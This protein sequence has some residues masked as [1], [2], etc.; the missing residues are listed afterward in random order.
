MDHISVSQI[1][2]L[3]RCGRQYELRYLEKV[4]ATTSG[5]LVKGS[6]YHAALEAHFHQAIHGFQATLDVARISIT[7]AIIARDILCQMDF[8]GPFLTPRSTMSSSRV[9]TGGAIGLPDFVSPC[10]VVVPGV[11]SAIA[12]RRWLVRG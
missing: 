8:R 4:P 5:A 7:P 6:V 12:G 11:C 10:C 3:L 1:N 9:S 2:T